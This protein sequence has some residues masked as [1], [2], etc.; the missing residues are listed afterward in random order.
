MVSKRKPRKR[1]N[2]GAKD[3]K[4]D[5]RHMDNKTLMER[6][7]EDAARWQRRVKEAQ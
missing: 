6:A 5:H 7:A 4:S 1:R 3:F 2:R